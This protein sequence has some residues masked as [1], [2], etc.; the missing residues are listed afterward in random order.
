MHEEAGGPGTAWAEGEW[1]TG[2][3]TTDIGSLGLSCPFLAAL[4]AV[5]KE[6]RRPGSCTQE[7]AG[8]K[9]EAASSSQK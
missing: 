2:A 5:A 9:G 7:A 1:R 3:T 4:Q 8:V 6:E